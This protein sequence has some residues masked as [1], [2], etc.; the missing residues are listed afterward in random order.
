MAGLRNALND[1]RGFITR[2]GEPF[3]AEN[4]STSSIPTGNS[5][6]DRKRIE[7]AQRHI[8]E[9]QERSTSFEPALPALETSTALDDEEAQVERELEDEF[10]ES[11]HDLW[12]DMRVV[13]RKVLRHAS[14]VLRSSQEETAQTT[15]RPQ[16]QTRS[17]T[18]NIPTATSPPPDNLIPPSTSTAAS[19]ATPRSA[20]PVATLGTAHNIT[21]IN[22]DGQSYA[23]PLDEI[24][25]WEVRSVVSDLFPHGHVVCWN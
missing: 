10:E 3:T 6:T 16:D 21:F 1:S 2:N 9:A 5:N 20:G 24:F 22:A 23:L 19:S 11:A 8:V 25:N 15:S 7:S 13:S 14:N 4:S 12:E 17:E 18:E